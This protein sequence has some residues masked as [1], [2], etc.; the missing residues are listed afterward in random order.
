MKENC[1]SGGRYC[2]LPSR[3]GLKGEKVLMQN[4]YHICV[5]KYAK[6]KDQM[7]IWGEYLYQFD[8]VCAKDMELTCTKKLLKKLKVTD[9]IEKCVSDSIDQKGKSPR[10]F[11]DDNKLLKEQKEKFE[12]VKNFNRFPLLK[13]NDIVY[14]GRLDTKNVM[15]FICRHVRDNLTG[16]VDYVTKIEEKKGHGFTIFVTIVVGVIFLW[17]FNKCRISL[18]MRFENEMNL[19][20]DQSINKF[21]A[22][23][24][25]N[26]L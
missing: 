22:K 18:R 12:A 5:E 9:K 8:K 10:I 25:G 6:K 2:A 7:L 14:Y 20:V 17:L 26:A 16:C 11:L 15:S 23:T 24:G 1:L 21:L 4:L 19:Q 13:I 3:D